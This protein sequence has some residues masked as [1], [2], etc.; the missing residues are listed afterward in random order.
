MDNY[1][2]KTLAYNKQAR[3]LFAD[4]TGLIS[5]ICDV[6]NIGKPLKLALG[7]TVSIASLISGTLKGN[8][9]ISI[10]VNASNRK[11]K[12][13][14]DADSMGNIRG[15]IN[16][17]L[18]SAPLGYINNISVEHIIGIEGCIQ[19]MKDLGMNSIFT[20]ITDMPYG[21]I[22]DDFSYYFNQSEQIPSLFSLNIV[23]NDNNEIVM[24]RGIMA[25]LLPGT[26]LKLIDNIK[27]IILKNQMVLCT[28]GKNQSLEEIVSSLFENIEI[29][30]SN[31]IQFFCGCSKEIFYPML[32]SLSREELIH[33]SEN[34]KPIEIVCNVCGKK[35]SFNPDEIKSLMQPC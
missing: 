11:Y 15:Y 32:H 19:V 20:G 5:E 22:V 24:S 1:I 8:Q 34:S 18:L 23:F 10:K 29:M 12:I 33:A 7:R 16:D 3:I 35:Y 30:E 9:R 14:A 27:G 13:F 2:I 28:S 26:P 4:N 17:G 21:N 31:Q 25:Q 6:K